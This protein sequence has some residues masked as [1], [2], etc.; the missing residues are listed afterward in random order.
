MT[1]RTRHRPLTGAGQLTLHDIG[2]KVD[3]YNLPGIPGTTE[4]RRLVRVIHESINRQGTFVGAGLPNTWL[5]RWGAFYPPEHP[6][7]RLRRVRPA[8]DDED[9]V[10]AADLT[11][12]HLG[13]NLQPLLCDPVSTVSPRRCWTLAEIRHDL[14]YGP[15]SPVVTLFYLAD[16][17]VIPAI[18]LPNTPMLLV[19]QNLEQQP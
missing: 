15:Q 18:V 5:Q 14:T 9:Q 12:E 19:R 4:V 1:G 7:L 2:G 17:Q 13:R 6:G 16:D 11:Y 3:D 10:T 8:L